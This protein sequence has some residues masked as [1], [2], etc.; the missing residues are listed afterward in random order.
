MLQTTVSELSL[1]NRA[2]AHARA[3]YGGKG[4]GRLAGGSTPARGNVRDFSGACVLLYVVEGLARYGSD[5]RTQ[6][7]L[8]R[9]SLHSRSDAREWL[10]RFRPS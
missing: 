6:R 10:L 8:L 4:D 1:S 3:Y 2:R 7:L 5:V 9:G